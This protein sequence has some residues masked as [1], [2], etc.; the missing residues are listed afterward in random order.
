MATG[1]MH[2]FTALQFGRSWPLNAAPTVGL[3][4]RCCVSRQFMTQLVTSPPQIDAVRKADSSFTQM[5][6]LV[7][8][9]SGQLRSL[10]GQ[11]HGQTIRLAACAMLFGR[12]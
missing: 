11:E 12:E 3:R 1:D 8:G 7:F 4:V 9:V 6:L 10:V 2:D 5:V